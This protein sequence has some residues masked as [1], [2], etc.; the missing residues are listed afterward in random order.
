V[1]RAAAGDAKATSTLLNEAR[2]QESQ[3]QPITQNHLVSAEDQMVMDNILQRIRLSQPACLGPELPA[4]ESS[5]E[6]P[7]TSI[8]SREG[9][10]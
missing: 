10:L 1:N 2:F 9:E 5:A 6:Q 8:E 7:T 3:S 4:G